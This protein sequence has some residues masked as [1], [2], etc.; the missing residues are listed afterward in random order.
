MTSSMWPDR[1]RAPRTRLDQMIGTFTIG[2]LIYAD[3][4]SGADEDMSIFQLN[5]TNVIWAQQGYQTPVGPFYHPKG[6]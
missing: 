4:G 5:G 6:I 2:D 1:D 3:H